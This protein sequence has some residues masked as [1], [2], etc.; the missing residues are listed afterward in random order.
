MTTHVTPLRG[1]ALRSAIVDV[2]TELFRSQGLRA[3]SADKVIE[4]VG[5][6]KVSFYRHFTSKDDLVV[7]YLEGELERVTTLLRNTAG[8][9]GAKALRI[10]LYE[11]LCAPGFRGCVF[12]NAAAEY[13]DAAHPARVLVDRFRAVMTTALAQRFAA[14]GMPDAATLARQVMM[15]RDG[16]LVSGYLEKQPARVAAEFAAGVD[17]LIVAHG[18][19][20]LT[21][22]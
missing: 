7:A 13:A 4:R 10:A 14:D 21:H 1:E 20:S 8:R 2:A 5:C 9:E 12:I 16:A 17:A 3:V 15:L 22:G 18:G 11:Q 19:T 6:S